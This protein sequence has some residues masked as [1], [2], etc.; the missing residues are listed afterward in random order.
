M[1]ITIRQGSE[2]NIQAELF[3]KLRNELKPL[4]FDVFGEV[5]LMEK[6]KTGGHFNKNHILKGAT[7]KQKGRLDIAIFKGS[8]IIGAVEVKNRK[9]KGWN[10][11]KKLYE[12]L[13]ITKLFLCQ[14]NKNIDYTIGLVKEYILTL[15][16]KLS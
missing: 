13:G 1:N 9:N 6:E 15:R 14:G 8:E 10:R 5:R 11:Q 3:I 16:N 12:K 4:G 2:F 7:R